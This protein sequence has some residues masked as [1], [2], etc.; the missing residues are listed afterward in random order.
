MK[1]V[2]VFYVKFSTKE[3][4]SRIINKTIVVPIDSSKLEV[5]KIVQTKFRAVKNIELIDYF[6]DALVFGQTI[7]SEPI[8]KDRTSKKEKIVGKWQDVNIYTV[9]F[10]TLD[11]HKSEKNMIFPLDYTDEKAEELIKQGLTNLKNIRNIQKIKDGWLK[12][13]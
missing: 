13:E 5:E 6:S 10:E 3:E 7:N 8:K 9:E 2:K 4:K 1:E 12:K 11:N